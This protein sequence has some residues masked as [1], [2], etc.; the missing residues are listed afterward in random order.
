MSSSGTE[1]YKFLTSVYSHHYAIIILKFCSH[2]FVSLEKKWSILKGKGG[3]LHKTLFLAALSKK[4]MEKYMILKK[5]FT[6]YRLK[7]HR[8]NK[9]SNS[10]NIA[11]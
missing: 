8:K 4:D 2:Y 7:L 3:S 1:K 5:I 6:L 11:I 10:F 9:E